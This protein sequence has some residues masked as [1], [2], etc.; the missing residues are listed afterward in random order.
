MLMDSNAGD[1]FPSFIR[2]NGIDHLV[3]YGKAPEWTLLHVRRRRVAFRGCR[4]VSSASTT[5]TS[6]RTDRRTI[7]AAKW[8]RDLGDGRT[9]R[10]AGENLVLTQR[11]HGRPEGIYARGGPGAKMGS[12][13]LKA[14]VVQGADARFR[15]R[16]PYKGHNRTIAQK[17]LDTSVVKNALKT[18]GTPFLYKPSRML[19]AMGTKN[20]Q[21]TTWTDRARRRAHR[22]RTA[23]AWRDVSAAR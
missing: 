11:H 23:P 20:N 1:Y 13:K 5:S 12:L 14:I 8:T 16:A 10:R 2:M 3:L 18:T 17:L 7:S 9:S 4:A 15:D 22:R 21:E 19:G 6:A